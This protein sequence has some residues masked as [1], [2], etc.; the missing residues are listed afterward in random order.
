MPKLQDFIGKIATILFQDK[1]ISGILVTN[2]TGD[3][4]FNGSIGF[5]EDMVKELRVIECSEEKNL[6][7][8]V[9]VL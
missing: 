8:V 7:R 2:G 1:A 6:C 9:V 4:G 3:F 5:K